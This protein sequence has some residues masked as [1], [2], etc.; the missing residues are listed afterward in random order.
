MSGP[1][2]PI[3]AGFEE[4]T[5]L[6]PTPSSINS[7]SDNSATSFNALS[8]PDLISRPSAPM[9]AFDLVSPFDSSTGPYAMLGTQGNRP[10]NHMPRHSRFLS[11]PSIISPQAGARDSRGRP[12]GAGSYAG[13]PQPITVLSRVPSGSAPM[14]PLTMPSTPAHGL[15]PDQLP[16]FMHSSFPRR[17]SEPH[18][19]QAA[20]SGRAFPV[21]YVPDHRPTHDIYATLFLQ[22][23][24][25]QSSPSAQYSTA[26]ST[27]MVPESSSR[28]QD[29]LLA[30]CDSDGSF[31]PSCASDLQDDSI[32][33]TS[34]TQS[35]S[36]GVPSEFMDDALPQQGTSSVPPPPQLA[37]TQRRSGKRKRVAHPKDPKAAQRLRSQRESE[38][39]ITQELYQLFVPSSAEMVPKK[40]RLRTILYHARR[41]TQT[42]DDSGQESADLHR[43]NHQLNPPPQEG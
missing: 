41:A 19:L 3:Y 27:H 31:T 40:D 7:Q 20:N 36:P 18:P 42:H 25:S 23:D 26:A 37:Q 16:A 29:D 39:G 43:G 12:V 1:L 24:F 34:F 5:S 33:V 32:S 6:M 4:G 22:P 8:P 2:S 38:E 9:H 14:I 15:P 10:L 28:T 35:V 30:F 21:P 11:Q 13:V 17:S